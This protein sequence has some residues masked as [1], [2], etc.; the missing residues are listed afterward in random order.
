MVLS[1]RE[2]FDF[3]RPV[4]WASSSSE[5]GAFFS[6]DAQQIAIPCREHLGEGLG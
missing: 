1:V 5:P 3:F 6:N 2:R 4:N